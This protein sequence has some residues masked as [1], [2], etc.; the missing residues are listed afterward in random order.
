MRRLLS[1]VTVIGLVA[2]LTVLGPPAE[3]STNTNSFTFTGTTSQ[4]IP[5]F[6]S[7]VLY[8]DGCSHGALA[9]N[10]NDPVSCLPD[11]FPGTLWAHIHVDLHTTVVRAAAGDLTLEAPDTLRQ[12]ATSTFKTTFVTKDASGKEFK[13]TTEPV[14][15]AQAAYDAPLA[16][17]PKDRITSVSQL[18]TAID[19]S[20][21]DECLNVY[22]ATGDIPLGTLTL[23]NQ[24]G[25]LPYSGTKTVSENH[26][27]PSVPL[28]PSVLDV[29][30]RFFTDLVLKALSGFTANRVL[31]ASG[32]PNTALDTAAL[33]WPDANAQLE[34]VK[35]PCGVPAGDDLLYKLK[36]VQ[37]G[38][39]GD[40]NV[41]VK[42]VLVLIGLFDVELP[43]PPPVTI[44]DDGDLTST[45]QPWQTDLGPVQAENKAPTV[46]L[47]PITGQP[48]GTP[49]SLNAVGTGPSGSFDNCDAAGSGLDFAWTFDDGGKAFGK[50]VS[51]AWNDNNGSADHSGQLVVTDPAGNKTT[52]NFSVTVSNAA[53]VVDAGPDGAA[54][55]GRIVSFAGSAADPGSADQSTLAYSWDFGD[56]TPSAAGGASALHSY[57]TPGTYT[58]TLTVRDK[59]GTS[60]SDTRSVVV[61]KRDVSVAWTGDHSG[62]FDTATALSASVVDEY[63]QAVAGRSVAMTVAGDNAGSATTNAAGTAAKSWTLAAL[64]PGNGNATASFAGDAL[65]NAGSTNQ[66]YGESVKGT[67]VKYTGALASTP[68]KVVTVSAVLTDASG[69]PLAGKTVTVSIGTQTATATTSATGVAT[70]TIKLNQ[71]NGTKPVVV[72]YAGDALRYAATSATATFKLG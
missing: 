64:V 62:V 21:S 48:E 60:A 18:T 15:S 30:V 8:Y 52:K 5:L 14:L 43:G 41:G 40:V 24:D 58:A 10:E 31:A 57:A 61:R 72:T 26:D 65:Y 6:D 42:P 68:N 63:N 70:S 28:I 29:K 36:D 7:G 39:Q 1:F 17:C 67:S 19:T 33:S 3:A 69:K 49:V 34:D 44:F 13:V 45:A 22:A 51:H 59:D 32:D 71:K 37:W 46:A 12:D 54:A 4:D 25:T 23:L 20:P 56:G 27:S 66:A 9:I 2:G 47:G 11:D 50:S 35:L 55:W 38:G 53:P 16:N